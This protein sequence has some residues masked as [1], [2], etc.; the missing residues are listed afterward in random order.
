[1]WALHLLHYTKFNMGQSPSY[2][3]PKQCVMRLLVYEAIRTADFQPIEILVWYGI[4]GYPIRKDKFCPSF[5][6]PDCLTVIGLCVG[7]IGPQ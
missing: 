7:S 2:E 1:M 3:Y 4:K 5:T 6:L